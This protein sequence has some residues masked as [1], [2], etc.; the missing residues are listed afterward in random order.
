MRRITTTPLLVLLLMAGQPARSAETTWVITLTCDGKVFSG[1]APAAPNEKRISKMSVIVNLAEHTVT[2][3]YTY[4]GSALIAHI[5]DIDDA[6]VHFSGSALEFPNTSRESSFLSGTINRV[7]G[8]AYVFVTRDARDTTN[9]L[10][11]KLIGA[12]NYHLVCK[13]RTACS[14]GCAASGDI[15]HWRPVAP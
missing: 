9:I 2:G 10:G 15:C 1:L 5:K 4:N 11:S 12:E 13:S 7:T 3:F 8:A 6:S 14:E